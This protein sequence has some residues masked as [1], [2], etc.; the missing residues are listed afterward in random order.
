MIRGLLCRLFG[1]R[2]LRDGA[3]YGSCRRCGHLIGRRDF[4]DRHE[5][6]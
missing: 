5:R 4:G 6:P 1:H 2:R 3:I